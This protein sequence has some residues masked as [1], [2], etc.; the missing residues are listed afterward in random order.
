MNNKEAAAVLRVSE[1]T[2]ERDWRL[3]R[4]WLFRELKAR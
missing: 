3:A 2:V 1:T 4:A